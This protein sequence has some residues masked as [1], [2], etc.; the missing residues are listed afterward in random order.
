MYHNNYIFIKT[1]RETK[2]P[3]NAEDSFYYFI[4]NSKIRF[5]SY[6]SNKFL[7]FNC[8]F[9]K[10]ENTSPYFYL[11]ANG[12]ME[13]VTVIS[14]KIAFI[15]ED[16]KSNIS[17]INR[18]N[19]IYDNKN[20]PEIVTQYITPYNFFKEN[21]RQCEISEAGITNLTRNTQIILFSKLYDNKSKKYKHIYKILCKNI[22]KRNKSYL[23]QLFK[24]FNNI[25]N[26]KLTYK[27]YFAITCMEY[28]NIEYYRNC[29]DVLTPIIDDVHSYVS[30]K[31][32]EN[33]KKYN[34]KDDEIQ[35]EYSIEIY[36]NVELSKFSERLKLI[37]NIARYEIIMISVNTG[38]SQGDY[39]IENLFLYEDIQSIMVTDFGNVKHIPKYQHIQN[40][41]S[42]LNENG[43]KI[44]SGSFRILKEILEDI[45]N[46]HFQDEDYNSKH[47]K[48]LKNIDEEDVPIIYNLHSFRKY[49]NVDS[50]PSIFEMYLNTRRS[51]YIYNSILEIDTKSPNTIT[52]CISSLFCQMV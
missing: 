38:Y 2:T 40:N 9:D 50:R 45:Y 12:E 18:Y 52:N 16:K 21:C 15:C 46:T 7:L 27:Y 22:N 47:Y 43:F 4:E 23:N 30:R 41:W 51:E 13:N 34:E 14:I 48:W 6:N 44:E 24:D 1:I 5:V 28:I 25:D 19:P 49:A 11:S 42:F 26:N 3:R 36:N 29:Y 8:F 33:I 32:M 37:Y 20:N 10:N 31:D 39:H 17:F 35:D